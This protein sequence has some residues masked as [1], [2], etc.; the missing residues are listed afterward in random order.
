MKQASSG[1]DFMNLVLMVG[2]VG[3]LFFSSMMVRKRRNRSLSRTQKRV[4]S[5]LGQFEGRMKD[6]KQKA[7][8]VSGEARQKVQE[9][10]HELEAKQKE[11]RG[12]LD[13]L[14]MEAKK[15]LEDVRS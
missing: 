7:G 12:K 4:G 2:I 1:G 6:L 8:T 10:V 11:L 3:L 9:Q 5:T 13:E 14:G 15:V